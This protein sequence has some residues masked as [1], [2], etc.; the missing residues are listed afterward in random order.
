MKCAFCG[1]DIETP[2]HR[3]DIIQYR[4]EEARAF[5]FGSVTCAR[6]FAGRMS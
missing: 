3:I 4:D 2:D 5:H 1:K 6:Q